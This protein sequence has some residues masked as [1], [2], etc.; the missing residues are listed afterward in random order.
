MTKKRWAIFS[1]A[2]AVP[3]SSYQEYNSLETFDENNPSIILA[4][5]GLNPEEKC[6]QADLFGKLSPETKK[7][8]ALINEGM[9]ELLTPKTGNLTPVRLHKYLRSTLKWNAEQISKSLSEMHHFLH[10]VIN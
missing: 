1:A 8:L 3:E 5:E 4:I 10:Q 2:M 9:L 7:V 6:I